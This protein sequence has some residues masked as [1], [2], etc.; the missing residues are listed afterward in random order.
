MQMAHDMAAAASTSINSKAGSLRHFSRLGAVI[1]GIASGAIAVS[2]QVSARESAYIAK[3][4]EKEA[5]IA[6]LKAAN[7]T[8]EMEKAGAAGKP[9][10]GDPVQDWIDSLAQ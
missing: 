3:I 5:E 8:L 4:A 2:S 10:S 6:E 7:Q 9:S 1:V